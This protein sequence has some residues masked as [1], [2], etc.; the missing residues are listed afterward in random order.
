MTEIQK[1]SPKDIGVSLWTM[2]YKSKSD[3]IQANK[4]Q[5]LQLRQQL[6]EA[7]PNT[8]IVSMLAC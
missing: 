4:A 6:C 5:S 2:K 7:V 1:S 3:C 8:A